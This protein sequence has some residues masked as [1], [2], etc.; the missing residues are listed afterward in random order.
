MVD[1]DAPVPILCG[2]SIDREMS[3][4]GGSY[5]RGFR[6]SKGDVRDELAPALQKRHSDRGRSTRADNGLRAARGSGSASR[7]R[8]L[9][10]RSPADLRWSKRSHRRSGHGRRLGD[11]RLH[12]HRK[13]ISRRR[14]PGRILGARVER[15]RRSR[16]RRRNETRSPRIRRSFGLQLAVDSS[17]GVTDGDIYV[18]QRFSNVVDIFS[19]TGKHIGE[20]TAGGGS[21]FEPC[22]SRSTMPAMSSSGASNPEPSTSTSRPPIPPPKPIT[23]RRS[24]RWC[25]PATSPLG[26]ARLLDRS[27]SP[28]SRAL[29]PRSMR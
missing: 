16:P 20:L 5:E 3:R 27:S 11:R 15:H 9:R 22:G 12:Q 2:G 1:R 21:S 14:H 28:P 6:E 10:K 26:P 13:P 4:T 23:R 18:T 25:S 24:K 8:K 17:G 19:E 29:S 7:T